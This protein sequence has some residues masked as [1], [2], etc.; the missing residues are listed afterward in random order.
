MS[1]S[2]DRRITPARPD[3]AA[4]YLKGRVSAT[5]YVEGEKRTVLA[6]QAPMRREPRADCSLDTEALRGET[7]TV[8]DEDEGWSWVQLARDSYVGYLP[9]EALGA[10]EL[11]THRVSVMRA[12]VFPGPNLKLPVVSALPF[13]ARVAVWNTSGR[14]SQIAEGWIWSDHLS[15][16]DAR[17][18]DFV[19]VAER[20]REVPYLWGGKTVLGL[21]CSGLVQTA[22][23]ATGVTC[24]RDSDM[25]QSNLGRALPAQT[26]PQRGDFV[27]WPGHVGIMQDN[28][29]LLHANGHA[30][31]VASEPLVAARD[32]IR[33]STGSDVAAIKR[34]TP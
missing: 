27:F 23:D 16:A 19:A 1:D 21:D 12:L 31:L 4:A 33:A 30:M 20:F 2:F 26:S 11:P 24:P 17:E 8:Y 22:L 5:T 15:P 32:R 18:S 3:R 25:Q 9:S 29:T 34:L 14:Y 13:G 28:Q 6:P 7:V 10:E